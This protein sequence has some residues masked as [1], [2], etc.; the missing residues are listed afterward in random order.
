MTATEQ[1]PVAAWAAP[2][3]AADPP[4][5]T[6]L[7]SG[8]GTGKDY[9]VVD[10]ALVK[11][12]AGPDPYNI[13]CMRQF[14]NSIADS[15]KA[16]VERRI[17]DHG[18]Q[19]QFHITH[20]DITCPA[21][22]SKMIFRGYE[23][24]I[25]SLRGLEG[26]NLCIINEAQTVLEDAARLFRY[27]VRE[28]N[29]RF[30]WVGNPRFRTDYFSKMLRSPP[31]GSLVLR[32]TQ[33]DN[34]WFPEVLRQDMENDRHTVWFAHVWGGQEVSLTGQVFNADMIKPAE[35]W[36]LDA[37]QR[38]RSWDLAGTADGGDY[39]VG[40]LMARNADGMYQIQNMVRGQWDSGA[41]EQRVLQSAIRD[42]DLTAVVIERGPGESGLS[43]RRHYGTVLDGYNFVSERP[44]G[45]KAERARPFAS[46]VN[47]GRVCLSD[48][49][50]LWFPNTEPDWRERLVEE[51][52]AFS[53]DPADM[54]RAQI[55]DDIVD[56]CSQAFNY[57]AKAGRPV[58][59]S[60][61]AG[62]HRPDPLGMGADTWM[63]I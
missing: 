10:Y 32:P 40:V 60:Y 16:L 4:R 22:G 37:V 42:T 43:Q 8:R 39:T 46:A 36:R 38:C 7:A 33:A 17:R 45:S 18:W 12:K 14:Q 58:S 35:G 9:A 57:L 59:L 41:V 50:R 61:D 53:E 34:P 63:P 2:L 13:A 29:S 54:K 3:W 6:F 51:L 19:S 1:V 52:A 15:I 20:N 26:I 21:T 31:P 47:N 49:D 11:M 55:H 56:A 44:S 5:D 28:E 24:N 25:E 30:I 48:N 27:S 62:R 23:R